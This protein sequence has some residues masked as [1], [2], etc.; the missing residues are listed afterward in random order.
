MKVAV[1]DQCAVVAEEDKLVQNSENIYFVEFVFDE[2]WDGFAK[3]VIFMTG[4]TKLAIALFEDK[5]ALPAE[6]IKRAGAYINIGIYGVRGDERKPTVWCKTGP[7]VAG[8][9][10]DGV[11]PALT[12]DVYTQLL[13]EIQRLREEVKNAGGSDGSSTGCGCEYPIVVIDRDEYEALS[14]KDPKTIYMIR[15]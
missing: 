14:E 4:S 5:C 12:P 11:L 8:A 2:T 10:L 3:T 9:F 15:G 6:C 7:V 1:T 13:T